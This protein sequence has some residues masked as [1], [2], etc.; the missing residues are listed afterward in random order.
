MGRGHR[1]TDVTTTSVPGINEMKQAQ[2]HQSHRIDRERYS[3]ARRRLTIKTAAV[4]LNCS[5]P[6]DTVLELLS[7][8]KA[9][10]QKIAFQS[11]LL[12]NEEDASSEILKTHDMHGAG[13]LS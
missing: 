3:L 11:D 8:T 9:H 1:G 4:R 6:A 7:K 2:R 10:L 12:T 13:R 5:A